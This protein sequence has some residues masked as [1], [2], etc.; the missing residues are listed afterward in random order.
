M[1]I[2]RITIEQ[3]RE[4]ESRLS[5]ES[6]AFTRHH[7]RKKNPHT[8]PA[9]S[10]VARNEMISEGIIWRISSGDC[11]LSTRGREYCTVIGDHDRT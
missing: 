8:V 5:E 7:A 6:R 2:A 11:I 3:A 1:T 10:N 4:I 9:V